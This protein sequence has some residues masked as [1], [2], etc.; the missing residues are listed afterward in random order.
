MR[1]IDIQSP[2][3]TESILAFRDPMS[4]R[5]VVASGLGRY[6]AMAKG[7]TTFDVFVSHGQRDAAISAEIARVLRS[8]GLKVFTDAEVGADE[9][10]EDVLWE[11]ISES[12]AFVTII[13][14][15]DP[16]ALVCA[17]SS[18]LQKPGTNPS[19]L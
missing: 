11:A 19:T 6:V 15:T 17:S 18:V 16:S 8:Y 7:K 10:V 13:S 9:A 1:A 12:Q 2:D 3:A 5:V 4:H 14:E